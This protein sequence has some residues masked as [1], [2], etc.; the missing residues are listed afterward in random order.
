[1]GDSLDRLREESEAIRSEAGYQLELVQGG[2]VPTDIRPTPDVGAGVMEIRIHG[3]N[4]YCVFYVTRFSESVYCPCTALP[5]KLGRRVR[6]TS[7][8]PGNGT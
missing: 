5:R 7:R 2:D 4:E 8:W 1:M 6:L 3:E